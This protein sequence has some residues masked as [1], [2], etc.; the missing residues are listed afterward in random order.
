VVFLEAELPEELYL[1][2][3]AVALQDGMGHTIKWKSVAD[4]RAANPAAPVAG[5][6]QFI[7]VAAPPME[8]DQTRHHR[9]NGNFFIKLIQRLNDLPHASSFLLFRFDL[10][11]LK[12]TKLTVTAGSSSRR[13]HSSTLPCPLASSSWRSLCSRPSWPRSS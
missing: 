10:V 9:K 5:H 7:S 3:L 4:D 6:N 8:L 11:H 13:G 12:V 1:Q 2:P